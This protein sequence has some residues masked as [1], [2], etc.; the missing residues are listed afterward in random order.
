MFGPVYFPVTTKRVLKSA[1]VAGITNRWNI[2]PFSN[3][4]NEMFL[5]LVGKLFRFP[6]WCLYGVFFLLFWWVSKR[7]STL[8]LFFSAGQ[9]TGE[10][11][12]QSCAAGQPAVGAYNDKWDFKSD[13]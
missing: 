10:H 9:P 12:R 8:F 3:P 2:S 11:P 5:I 4:R 7:S 6:L 13:Y 1:L